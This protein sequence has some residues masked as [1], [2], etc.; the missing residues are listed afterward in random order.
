M[1][2]PVY[3]V[4]EQE[5]GKMNIEVASIG[6][7]LVEVMRKKV[8]EPLGVPGTFVGPF[9]SGAPAIFID[10]VARL[11]VRSG[12]IGTVGEDDFG[13]L[14]LRRLK[15]DNVDTQY[16]EISKDY[17]TGVA[18][19]TYFRDGTRKFIFHLS[20]AAS[21]Q[22]SL[23]QINRDY[24]SQVKYLHIMGSSL[25]I[26]N[27]VQ[28]ACYEAVKIIKDSQGKISFDPNL[29]VELLGV[30]K[31]RKICQPLLFSCEVILPGEE[32]VKL[33]TG[34][35]DVESACERLLNYG[36]KI[37]A[38]K[39]GKRGAT[40]FTLKEKIEVPSFKV[41]EVDP[42]GAGDCF[43]AG[44]IVGL[45]K[46]WPLKKIATFANAVGALAVTK[47]G[48]MEG[49]PTMEEVNRLLERR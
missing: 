7:L 12:F 4:P 5:G 28:K 29:R 17:T 36:I 39:Q 44:F 32:E 22:I 16:I 37:V 47:K 25:S 20:R 19:V 14:I 41:K 35:K 45:L 11:G 31:I 24:L 1:T 49:A 27:Q 21:G 2:I 38:L 10:T 48:P 3:P 40:I 6:E 26:N 33:L 42:T 13:K 9:P 46:E 30:N 23:K 15:E 8:D 18:F 34:E 43:D